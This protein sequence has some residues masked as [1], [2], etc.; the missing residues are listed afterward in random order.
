[1]GNA[2]YMGFVIRDDLE[3]IQ[4]G[5]I[6]IKGLISTEDV[7]G[8]P[9]LPRGVCSGELIAASNATTSAP[10][11]FAGVT[12]CAAKGRTKKVVLVNKGRATSSR[13]TRRPSTEPT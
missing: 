13:Q 7:T 11:T 3:K 8:V 1:M 4:P 10:A 2:E 12:T 9:E 6:D 5:P